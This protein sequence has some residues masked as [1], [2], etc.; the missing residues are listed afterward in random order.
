M[1]RLRLETAIAVILVALGAA[2]RLLPHPPNFAPIGALALYGGAAFSNR[3]ST[4]G[5]PLS[6]MALSDVFLGFYEPGVMASV[7]GSFLLTV[8]IGRWVRRNV[9]VVRVLVGA[10]SGSL[11]FFLVTNLAVWA[12]GHGYPPTA[13]GLLQSYVN[14]L[15]F[16][17]NT[18]A[19]DLFYS[20]VF[21]GL[22]AAVGAIVRRRSLRPTPYARR[23]PDG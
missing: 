13:H 7:Y 23:P 21:F 6:A 16:Y 5:I 8:L 3:L 1:S 22:T 4:F 20:G 12:F 19:S 9:S 10:L 2:L 11:I 15:P 14:A 18:L 17:R